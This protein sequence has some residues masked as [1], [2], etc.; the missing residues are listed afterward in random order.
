MVIAG[1]RPIKIPKLNGCSIKFLI[2]LSMLFEKFH[3]LGLKYISDEN[4]KTKVVHLLII[5]VSLGPSH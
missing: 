1:Y 4:L 2:K 3:S 5:Q